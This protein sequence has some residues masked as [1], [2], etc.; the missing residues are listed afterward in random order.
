M[1]CLSGF[2]VCFF[3]LYLNILFSAKIEAGTLADQKQF[4]KSI[5]N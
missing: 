1:W 4:T 5:S 2:L 3:F